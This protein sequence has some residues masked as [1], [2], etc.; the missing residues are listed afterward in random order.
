MLS[1][2]SLIKEYGS[3]DGVYARLDEIKKPALHRNLADNE[4]KAYMSLF[5]VTIKTDCDV[6]LDTEKAGADGY[7]TREAFELCTELG[8]KNFLSRFE[9][10]V[11]ICRN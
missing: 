10:G 4:D 2:I 1:A 8:F 3:V 11:M 5:L 7:F 9:R 6:E